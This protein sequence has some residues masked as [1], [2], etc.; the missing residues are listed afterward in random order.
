VTHECKAKTSEGVEGSET[1]VMDEIDFKVKASDKGI[2]I[3]VK[4]EQEIEETT[5]ET[6]TET[7]TEAQFEVCFQQLIEYTKA[8]GSTDDAYDWVNDE[9]LQ[10]ID[11]TTWEDFSE[12][13]TDSTD[14][15]STFSAETSDGLVTMTFTILPAGD[16]ERITANSMKAD[17]RLVDFPWTPDAN[18]FVALVSDVESKL[19]VEVDEE[20]PDELEDVAQA[21]EE[22]EEDVEDE[23]EEEPEPTEAPVD[24]PEPTEGEPVDEPEPIED[25]EPAENDVEEPATRALDSKPTKPKDVKISFADVV[26]TV[27][28]SPLG[29]VTWA[30]TAI[31]ATAANATDA[32]AV[33]RAEKI[34][35][36]VATSPPEGSERYLA[37]KTREQIAFSFIGDGAQG[38][39]DIFW[40]PEAGVDY[41]VESMASGVGALVSSASVVTGVV[42]AL[43]LL[44]C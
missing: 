10:S 9:V 35:Q 41:M 38:S 40:D 25:E 21:G 26:N 11:L 17:F 12:V 28:F 43:L 19:K 13:L 5:A 4:Y 39:P 18:G 1:E 14:G 36:V 32:V 27:G 29:T 42:S 3:D 34:I 33:G 24:E 7:E 44:A 2:C 31:A 30:E 22:P 8:Q 37:D 16:G 23:P 20:E 15:M 6:E